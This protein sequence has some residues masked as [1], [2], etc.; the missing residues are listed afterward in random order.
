MLAFFV[1]YSNLFLILL[2]KNSYYLFPIFT[3]INYYLLFFFTKNKSSNKL[4]SFNL[5]FHFIFFILIFFTIYNSYKIEGDFLEV[6]TFYNNIYILV[7][8]IFSL[9]LLWSSYLFIV[10]SNKKEVMEKILVGVQIEAIN[11]FLIFISM[12]I[13][14]GLNG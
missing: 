7:V 6:N 9:V 11:I 8:N 12:G 2:T 5:I 10:C 1:T 14:M 13:L 3:I 4:K